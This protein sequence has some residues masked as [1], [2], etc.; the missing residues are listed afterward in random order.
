MKKLVKILALS[1]VFVFCFAFGAC[2]G[3][4]YKKIETALGKAGFAVNQDA[5]KVLT[6]LKT[7]LQK[8][9]LAVEFHVLERKEDLSG[10]T[11]IPHY[12]IV[13]EFKATDD[14]VKACKES[15]TLGGI[16]KDALSSEDVK[17]TYNKLVES[18]WANGNCLVYAVSGSDRSEVKK[19]VKN[20]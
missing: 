10:S 17:E 4:S 15:N 12:V 1:L 18:G 16:V 3:S 11:I 2:G 14:L 8:D 20:A 9:D 6:T 7:E 13:L 5:E 19:I